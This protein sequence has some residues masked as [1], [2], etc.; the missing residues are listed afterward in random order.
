MT[1]EDL[2][3]FEDNNGAHFAFLFALTNALVL[4]RAK[5]PR[6]R[7]TTFMMRYR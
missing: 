4:L 3:R 2:R 6:D 5:A 7:T 1:A